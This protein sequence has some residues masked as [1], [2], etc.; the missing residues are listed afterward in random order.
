MKALATAA[1]GA[2]GL[3]IRKDN[4]IIKS[5]FSLYNMSFIKKQK[6]YKNVFLSCGYIVS[7]I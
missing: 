7:E 5:Y 2:N 4:N 6:L 1:D 3:R